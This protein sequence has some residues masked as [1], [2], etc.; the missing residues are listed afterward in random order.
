MSSLTVSYKMISNATHN[1]IATKTPWNVSMKD[2]VK[3]L[4]SLKIPK[5]AN[6]FFIKQII[7]CKQETF[8]F[9]SIVLDCKR[10]SKL[11]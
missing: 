2:V 9:D 5:A 11:R 6:M 4:Q 7:I 3:Y 8:L 10:S 1:E